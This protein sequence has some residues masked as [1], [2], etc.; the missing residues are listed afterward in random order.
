M[1]PVREEVIPKSSPCGI[2]LADVHWTE[3][4]PIARAC[5]QPWLEVQGKYWQQVK[6]LHHDLRIPIFIAGDLFDR[7][8]PSHRLVNH[9]LSWLEG[10]D[11]YAIP[12]NHDTPE[13]NYAELD[14]S[15]FKTLVM[16]GTVKALTP[17]MIYTINNMLIHPYPHGFQVKPVADDGGMLLKVALIH[18]YVWTEKTGFPGAPEEDRFARWKRKLGGYDAAIFGDN[19][20]G[21]LIDKDGQ[22][23]FN[24]GTFMRR[25]SD[26]KEY[27][28]CVGILHCD[29]SMKKHYLNPGPEQWIDVKEHALALGGALSLDLSRFAEELSQLHADRVD[30]VKA[31]MAW[32]E[33]SKVESPVKRLLYKA[34]GVNDGNR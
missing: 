28:P 11:I 29:G 22:V 14:R 21:F 30:Y 6:D 4:P 13:H 2:F 16:A 27:K 34:L 23:V 15:A 19:H 8:N 31:C 17:R 5:Q 33:N 24:C 3:S 26:E 18:S 1:P 25:H 20:K 32:I 10:C 9:V 7:W 12:G